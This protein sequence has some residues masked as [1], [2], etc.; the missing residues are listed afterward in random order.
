MKKSA[1]V[2]RPGYVIDGAAAGYQILIG[3]Q[4][5]KGFQ[6]YFALVIPN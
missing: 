4:S 2:E 6:L 1:F 3:N 5:N